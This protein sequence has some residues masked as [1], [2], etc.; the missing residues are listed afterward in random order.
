VR[1]AIVWLLLFLVMFFVGPGALAVFLAANAAVAA[2]QMCA[3]WNERGVAGNGVIAAAGAVAI[4]LA[5]WLGNVWTGAAILLFVV[6][7]TMSSSLT[8]VTRG[9]A[10]GDT[11][12]TR[13]GG[14]PRRTLANAAKGLK[15][16][17]A[18]K[19]AKSPK[20]A[21]S[22]TAPKPAAAGGRRVSNSDRGE[23]AV[24]D[25]ANSWVTLTA[26]F[27]PGLAVAASVQTLRLGGMAFA[28]LAAAVCTYDAGDHLCSAG[29]ASRVVGPASGAFGV[30]V[31]TFS[32]WLIQPEPFTSPWVLLTGLLL[33]VLC[34]AGQWL[35]SWMLPSAATDAP[36]LRRLDA[37]F[38]SAPVF[39]LITA[40]LS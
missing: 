12:G 11:G 10:G 13:S 22:T 3:R 5:A 38:L 26:G 31:V 35:A 17:R 25:L 14:T 18:A 29:Y 27:V 7:A 23:A 2:L 21:R 16:S 6:V 40:A 33:A 24:I 36:G 8:S 37:W 28:F 30:L 4:S 15:D 20:S 32:M 34:P 39:W 9:V 19:A 1:L